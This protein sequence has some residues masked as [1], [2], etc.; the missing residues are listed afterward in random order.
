MRIITHFNTLTACLS[1]LSYH[2]EWQYLI[3][4]MFTYANDKNYSKMLKPLPS[5]VVLICSTLLA[6]EAMLTFGD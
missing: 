1:E 6:G 3:S 4:G 5:L 2:E